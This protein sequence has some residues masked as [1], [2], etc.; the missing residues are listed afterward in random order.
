ML[1]ARLLLAEHART[2][3]VTTNAGQFLN[4]DYV[5]RGAYPPL[6]DRRPRNTELA[7]QF[8]HVSGLFQ[9]QRASLLRVKWFFSCHTA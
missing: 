6:T 8:R 7:A 3:K 1:K 9:R 2:E 5:F 4:P